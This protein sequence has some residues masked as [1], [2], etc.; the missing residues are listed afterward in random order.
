MGLGG[1]GRVVH[2]SRQAVPRPVPPAPHRGGPRDRHLSARRLPAAGHPR[3]LAAA[4][5]ARRPGAGR[6]QRARFPPTPSIASFTR[7]ARACATSSAVAAATSAGF[8]TWSSVPAMR[9]R[10]RRCCGQPSTPMPSSSRSAGARASPAA[11]R[12]LRARRAPWCRSTSA[13]WTGC[14]RSTQ[15]HDWRGC[16]PACSD[17]GSRSSSTRRDGRSGT[18]RTASRTRRSAAGS[19]PAPRGCS[20]TC[21]AT[22]PT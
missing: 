14:C 9:R 2:A 22:S 8:P 6:G 5:S 18:S 12:L 7:A 15:G 16:R 20:P 13:R 19:P 4:R 3:A 17:P 11:S 10:W 21:T 1:R